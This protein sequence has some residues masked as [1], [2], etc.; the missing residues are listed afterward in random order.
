MNAH[1]G[2]R[3]NKGDSRIAPTITGRE[4]VLKAFSYEPVDRVP[5]DS[6]GTLGT[7]AHV[8]VIA[9]LRRALGLDKP[10]IPVKVVEPYQMLGEVAGC[11]QRAVNELDVGHRLHPCRHERRV[12][13]VVD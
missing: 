8:S 12:D 3:A 11:D 6:G 2:D 4:R 1:F 10:G 13:L 9:N 5:V 7:G